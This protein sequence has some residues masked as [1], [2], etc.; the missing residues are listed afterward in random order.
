MDYFTDVFATFLSL[1]HVN[2]IAVYGGSESSRN[3]RV[4]QAKEEGDLQGLRFK[5][6]YYSSHTQSYRV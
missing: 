6:L 2:Y 3:A 4:L 1:D 5:V